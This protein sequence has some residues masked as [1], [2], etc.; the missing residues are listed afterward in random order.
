MPDWPALGKA[1]E[2]N[3]IYA[4]DLAAARPVGG[5]DISSAWQVQTKTGPVFLKTAAANA[6]D[7]FAAEADG[8]KELKRADAVRVPEVLAAGATQTDRFL[9]LEWLALGANSPDGDRV[10]GQQLAKL[11]A[12]TADR[13]GWKRNNTIG[14]T[15][16]I[17]TWADSW[18]NFY[19]EQRLI[20]QLELA[21]NN[22]FGSALKES[23]AELTE[24][25]SGLFANYEP[26][27]SLLHGDLWAGNRSSINGQP[28]IFDPAVYYG[29]RETDLAMTEL[30]GGFS[31]DFYSAYRA[32][33]PLDE[34]YRVRKKLYNLYHVLNHLN[35]FGGGYLAQAESIIEGL[36]SE[37]D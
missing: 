8:L 17:N 31:V 14:C 1:L 2:K 29:D 12:Q 27:P 30:F 37:I 25:L 9:A 22:G 7:S 11:H 19:R 23:G 4:V 6:A 13:F 28:V 32:A 34:G 36:L 35:L 21:E 18:V 5:G 10:F 24:K 3:G 16:Q 33:Y 26:V 15:P 20:F